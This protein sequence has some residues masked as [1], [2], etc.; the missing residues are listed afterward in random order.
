MGFHL[1]SSANKVYEHRLLSFI[2]EVKDD[3]ELKIF[4]LSLWS[5]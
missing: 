4:L 2:V 1:L 5:G 3:F